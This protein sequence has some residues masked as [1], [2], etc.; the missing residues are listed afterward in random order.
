MKSGI[1]S[2]P[3]L[4]GRERELEILQQH[5]DLAL[6][7]KGT[8]LFVSGEAGSGKTRLVNE[9][10][11]ASKQ[12]RAITQL[13]GW[14]LSNSGVP[15]FPFI[16]AFNVYSSSY[17]KK[18]VSSGT[19]PGGFEESLEG[20][21]L[22]VEEEMGLRAWLMGPGKTEKS[23]ELEDLSPQAWK[24][25][26]FAAVTKALLSLS[27]KKPTV[28]FIDDL[29]W[30]DTASLALLQYISRFIASERVFILSTFRSEDLTPDSEGH[31]HPLADTLRLMSRENLYKEIKLPSLNRT[32]VSLLAE[33]MV[34]GH[35]Q[36]DLAEKLADE[37]QGNPLF[38]VESLK[39]LSERGDLIQENDRWRLSTSEIGIP[40]KIKDILLRRI[41]ALKPPQRKMLE[42]ASV[43]GSMF[44]PEL[45][46]SVTG[47][48]S[49]DTLETLGEIEKSTS[50][51]IGEGDLY[52]F[53]HA[54]YR[55][56]LYEEI[57]QPLKRAY[58]GRIA[59]KIESNQSG[60]GKLPV[61]DLAFHYAEAGNK[62]KAV[63]YALDAG[64]EALRIFN[65]AD[66]I[67]LFKY[68]L[69]TTTDNATFANERTI[70]LEGFGDGLLARARGQEAAYVFEKLA[71]NAT[72]DTLKMRAFR[73]AIR[74]CL[75]MGEFSRALDLIDKAVEKPEIDRLE[76][77][78]LRFAKAVTL[79]WGG[80]F[81]GKNLEDM[82]QSLRVFEGEYS[83]S[84]IQEALLEM[85]TAYM[86]KDLLE[87]AVATGLRSLAL[88]EYSR[89]AERAARATQTLCVV[90]S[91]VRLE[92]EGL[93]ALSE[94]FKISEKIS[95][96][97][98][99]A[100]VETIS[101]W[102]S[103]Q[104]LEAQAAG[105]M[106]SGLPLESMRSFGAGAKIKF[107][108]SSLISGAFGEFKRGL[109]EALSMS[110]KGA[111]YAEQTNCYFAL[112]FNY[113]NLLREYATLGDME[114]AEKY[115]TLLKKLADETS[116]MGIFHAR[117]QYLSSKAIYHSS[118]REW[119]EA[120][121]FHEAA[122][123]EFA[124]VAPTP[125]AAE[126]N[127]AVAGVRQ[128]YCWSLLQQGRFAD[129][130]A[131]FEKARATMDSLDKRFMHSIILGH[132]IAPDT[133]EVDKEFNMRLDLANV[134][135]SPAV[136][137]K[138]EA[139]VPTEFSIISMQPSYSVQNGA[140]ELEKK[141]IKPFTD[142][143][144]TFAVKARKAGEFNLN[145]QLI[146]V[147]DLGESKVCK[148]DPISI[149]VLQADAES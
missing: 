78:R 70:A 14:C 42:I 31:P 86:S 5:F 103:G 53:D 16:E 104:L 11:S 22:V 36:A 108:M 27:A 64:E 38:V 121:K 45:L 111:E 30:A 34:G 28:L 92:E 19:G 81:V 61:G 62:E 4:V 6:Q 94:S 116:V 93:K 138:I 63:K 95:D 74:A 124:S 71:S 97:I 89:S 13:S 144:I 12:K 18:G 29:Q 26:T 96:P 148:V 82:E 7:G 114:Q 44:N 76:S 98:S 101:Y 55:D 66:A 88:S 87:K 133:V 80:K 56:A 33:D 41:G 140:M 132:L 65:G 39:M 126:K 130:K 58:H 145:P 2:E 21:E 143:A 109:K 149:T 85:I 115:N 32:N 57:S 37:S 75:Y 135:K 107:F 8:T 35:V 119:E 54:K 3:A 112:A 49:L 79:A 60:T 123:N 99:R 100:W 122:I 43:I 1:I 91:T 102:V 73:K 72:F 113:S 50:L 46:A 118:K 51:V 142:E 17:N 77:A 134:A 131:H 127:M 137:M 147:N 84:D 90:C 129:A 106:F 83:L 117:A 120:N 9:F 40:T 141:S 139:I 110:L 20:A 69:D 23:R 15:Y 48:D 59:E 25:S 24:D 136:L 52:R 146:Y 68:V 47:Q 105:K 128:S 125:E 67:K 10:L